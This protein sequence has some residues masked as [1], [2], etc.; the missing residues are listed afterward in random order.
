MLRLS[1]LISAGSMNTA[2]TAPIKAERFMNPSFADN[3]F[4][5]W[6]DI[7]NGHRPTLPPYLGDLRLTTD[8]LKVDRPPGVGSG[9]TTSSQVPPGR[10]R[11]QCC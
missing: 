6:P 8:P 10:R 7:P 9:T 3:S 2:S 4:A 1:A 11:L 5:Q